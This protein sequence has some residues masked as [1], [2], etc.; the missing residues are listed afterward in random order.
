MTKRIKMHFHCIIELNDDDDIQWEHLPEEL[1]AYFNS[2]SNSI[3]VTEDWGYAPMISPFQSP[4]SL[5]ERVFGI[6]FSD[7]IWFE[8][9]QAMLDRAVKISHIRPARVAKIIQEER[10]NKPMKNEWKT[11]KKD[12]WFRSPPKK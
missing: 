4:M 7:S 8:I 5:K 6:E 11:I 1:Q 10:M 2:Y 9:Q 3:S 12:S